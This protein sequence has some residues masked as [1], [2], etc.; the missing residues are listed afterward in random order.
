MK[1][2]K[3]ILPVIAFAIA[4]VASAFT[5]QKHNAQKLNSLY[6]Y[7]VTYDQDHPSGV[8]ASS[9][10]F[11][12]QD[13]KTNVTS[14]CTSGSTLDCLRGFSSQLTSFPTGSSGSDQI[15]KP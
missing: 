2:I 5:V 14:P 3:L 11:Y 6:W 8:I 12:V 13:E 15:K 4:L 7:E 10:D 9:A 1:K